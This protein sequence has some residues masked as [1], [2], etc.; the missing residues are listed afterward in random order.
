MIQVFQ[1]NSNNFHIF[2][3]F[4][5]FQSNGNNLFTITWFGLVWFL[6][7]KQINLCELF[8]IKAILVEEHQ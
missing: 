7:L 4:Q 1:Y 6:C 8:N 2:V 5:V 3:L